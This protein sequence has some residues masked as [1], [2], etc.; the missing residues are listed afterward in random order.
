MLLN[1]PFII[2]NH[3]ANYVFNK[4]LYVVRLNII[5]KM[6]ISYS[7]LL[8]NDCKYLMFNKI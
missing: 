3:I 8:N 4:I 7:I 2:S 5:Y 6:Q 1:N